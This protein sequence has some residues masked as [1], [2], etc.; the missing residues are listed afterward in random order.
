MDNMDV[1][2]PRPLQEKLGEAWVQRIHF[3]GALIFILSLAV[4]G[5]FYGVREGRGP[6]SAGEAFTEVLAVVP[7]GLRSSHRRGAGGRRRRHC[8]MRHSGPPQLAFQGTTQTT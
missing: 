2:E 4:I 6:R 1:A 3:A 7:L 8:D 5:L